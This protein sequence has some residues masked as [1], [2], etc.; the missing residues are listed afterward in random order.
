MTKEE[1]QLKLE[2]ISNDWA[3]ITNTDAISKKEIQEIFKDQRDSVVKEY[4]QMFA[5]INN[6]SVDVQFASNDI[7]VALN[8]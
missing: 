8:L 1:R 2:A 7:A 6:Y 3:D 5:C 4:H